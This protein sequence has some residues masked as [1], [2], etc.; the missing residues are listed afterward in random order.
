[1]PQLFCSRLHTSQL[2]VGENKREG[3]KAPRTERVLVF[4]ISHFWYWGAGATSMACHADL[5]F[6]IIVDAP[7]PLSAP[8]SILSTNNPATRE[9][10][11]F[12][13]VVS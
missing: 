1:M 7:P 8:F 4:S 3:T 5:A 12:W 2:E 10:Q 13:T 9:R 11:T 6:V